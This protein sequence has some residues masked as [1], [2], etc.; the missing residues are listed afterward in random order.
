L[1]VLLPISSDEVKL[2][3]KVVGCVLK[4]RRKT[5]LYVATYPT[6]LQVKVEDFEKSVL[7]QQQKNGKARVLGI[8]G[9][10]GA[11]KTTLAKELFNKKS[12]D[13]NKSSFLFDVR[14]TA[15]LSSLNSLQSKLLKDLTQRTEQIDSIA[16]GIEILRR[17]LSSLHALVVIDDVDDANQL[18][19]FLPIILF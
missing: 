16:E 12:C 11:G 3:E 17:Y 13:F 14:E 7:L 8:V 6:G 15:R 18:D 19:A 10:G 4:N 5:A 2:L 9:L 1:F